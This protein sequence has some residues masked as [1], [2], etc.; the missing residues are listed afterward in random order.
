MAG[1][2]YKVSVMI[3]KDVKLEV[4][5]SSNKY[6]QMNRLYIKYEIEGISK[7]YRNTVSHL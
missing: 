6:M 7:L 2:E 3:D 1:L 5:I 4:P